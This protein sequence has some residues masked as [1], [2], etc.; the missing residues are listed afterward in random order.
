MSSPA[1]ANFSK[2]GGGIRRTFVRSAL[3]ALYAL[4][5]AWLIVFSFHLIV[6][7]IE[8]FRLLPFAFRGLRAGLAAWLCFFVFSV[9]LVAPDS[10]LRGALAGAVT[11]VVYAPLAWF[12]ALAFEFELR[13]GPSST[14]G[15]PA[16][17]EGTRLL[18]W[19]EFSVLV[20][21]SVPLFAFLGFYLGFRGLREI[22]DRLSLY[23]DEP[24]HF[25]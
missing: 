19:P 22:N 13:A 8:L 7:D 3:H 2:A 11:G 17:L 25:R 21:I 23:D 20:Y 16:I 4:S 1:K 14:P 6:A 12:G 5:L 15:W 9:L 18:A 10:P 24:Q